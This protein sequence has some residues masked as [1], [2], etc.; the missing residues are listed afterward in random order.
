MRAPPF[1]N[2]FLNPFLASLMALLSPD[3]TRAEAV[4]IPGPTGPLEAEAIAVD[5]ATHV[6]VII[7]GSG[8][9]DRDGNNPMGLATDTYRMIAA[10]LAAQ[11]IASLRIDKRGYAGSARAVADPGDIDVAGYVD[12]ARAWVTRARDMAPCV[13]LAGHSEGGLI[14]LLAAAEPPEGLCG[15]IL[16]AAPGRPIGRLLIEQ[17]GANPATSA[18]LPQVESIVADLEAGRT[19]DPM[20]LPPALQPMFQPGLQRYMKGLFKWDPAQVAGDWSGPALILQGDADLQVRPRDADLLAAAMPQATRI[21]L[22]GATHMLKAD[23]PGQPLAGY[24]DR[25]LPLDPALVPAI[26]GFLAQFDPPG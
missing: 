9:T 17:M 6:V 7:P 8:P 10:G 26:A 16:M 3:P 13:W 25:S 1:L 18:L 15:L 21:D 20:T 11:G 12:D 19:R 5:N 24:T 22:P 4:R 2:T 23:V 14:A